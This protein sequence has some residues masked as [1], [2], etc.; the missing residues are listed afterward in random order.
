MLKNEE[1]E[2]IIKLYND[3]INPQT[4]LET[5]NHQLSK[6]INSSDERNKNEKIIKT[7][8][9]NT[10]SFLKIFIS[11]IKNVSSEKIHIFIQEKKK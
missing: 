1:E 10:I 3:E 7:T 5:S 6:V 8:K 9:N 4:N 11:D 2:I